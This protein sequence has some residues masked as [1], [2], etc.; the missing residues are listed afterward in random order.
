MF[1]HERNFVSSH[2]R[3]RARNGGWY[4]LMIF[5]ISTAISHIIPK[6]RTST[7]FIVVRWKDEIHSYFNILVAKIF[8]KKFTPNHLSFL[9]DSKLISNESE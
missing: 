5:A 9:N 7:L 1:E 2:G 3:D 4:N 8:K 6:S